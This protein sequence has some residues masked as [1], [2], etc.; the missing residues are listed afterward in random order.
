[1]SFESM[2]RRLTGVVC[3]AGGV[4]LAA[5]YLLHFAANTG[6][7]RRTTMVDSAKGTMHAPIRPASMREEHRPVY[8]HSIIRGGAYSS[9]ELKQALA[10]DSVAAVHY[11]GFRTSDAHLDRLERPRLAYLSYRIGKS[12]RWTR[13]AVPLPAGEAVLT[14]GT[15][16]ARARCGNRISFT[17]QEPVGPEVDLDTPEAPPAQDVVPDAGGL[18]DIY[19]LPMIVHD[20]FAP[21]YGGFPGGGLGGVLVG[22]L[23]PESGGAGT[24]GVYIGGF[25]GGPGAGGPWLSHQPS[26]PVPGPNPPVAWV[27]PTLPPFDFP[28]TWPI[29]VITFNLGSTPGTTSAPPSV[30]TISTGPPG[31]YQVVPPSGSSTPPP[32]GG[33]GT[34]PEDTPPPGDNPPGGNPPGGNPPPTFSVPPGSPPPPDL[35]PVP[36]TEV[37][38]PSAAVSVGVGVAVLGMLRGLR[39]V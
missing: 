20:L 18:P 32:S 33:G 13:R 2:R 10:R 29:G 37:P 38:E 34:P 31:Y 21:Y 24:Q 16:L 19:N 11:A 12:V 26:P 7:S 3:L 27:P 1:M 35:P 4:V 22:G 36:D 17:P 30:T 8:P 9:V 25:G 5:A 15:H 23:V 14:D 39:R 28:V 6:T